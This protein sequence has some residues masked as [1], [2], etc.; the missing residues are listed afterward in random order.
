MLT[1]KTATQSHQS[2]MFEDFLKDK[3]A[4]QYHGLDD[5]MPDDFERWV[6]NLDAQELIDFADQAIVKYSAVALGSVKTEKKAKSSRANGLK[7]GRPKLLEVLDKNYKIQDM[8]YVLYEIP[9]RDLITELEG[10]KEFFD[11]SNHFKTGTRLAPWND[12]SVKWVCE[13]HPEKEWEVEC[14]CG[15]GMPEPTPENYQKGYVSNRFKKYD[16]KNN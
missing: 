12:L 8:P 4:E 7:G 14:S 9:E 13:N 10:A 2:N 1:T 11:C 15:A 3:H 5:D 16:T 6:S